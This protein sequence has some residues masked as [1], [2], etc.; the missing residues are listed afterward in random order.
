MSGLVGVMTALKDHLI[1]ST[2]PG[3]KSRTVI[4]GWPSRNQLKEGLQ[5]GQ[6]FISV[7]PVPKAEK[8]VTTY[9]PVP[10]QITPV[11]STTPITVVEGLR[12]RRDMLV[13]IWA[14]SVE[15]RDLFGSLIEGDSALFKMNPDTGRY[16]LLLL[17]DGSCALIFYDRS[18]LSDAEQPQKNWRWCFEFSVE[19]GILTQL[20]GATAIKKTNLDLIAVPPGSPLPSSPTTPPYPPAPPPEVSPTFFNQRLNCG[21][22]L[23][24]REFNQLLSISIGPP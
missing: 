12:V 6:T 1:M 4:K 17:P 18:W 24:K 3:G 20:D 5:R 10:F 16:N 21:S 23:A 19:Y 9:F 14:P 22:Y 7:Y 8:N 15:K 2:A 13:N 11:G